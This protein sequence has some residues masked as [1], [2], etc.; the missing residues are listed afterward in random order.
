MAITVA[1]KE[2]MIAHRDAKL[3]AAKHLTSDVRTWEKRCVAA[4]LLAADLPAL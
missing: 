1:A 2:K 4:E 3:E